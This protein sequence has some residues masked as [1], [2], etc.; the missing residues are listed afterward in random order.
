[1]VN[2]QSIDAS[3]LSV[4]YDADI[5]A[6]NAKALRRLAADHSALYT[7]PLPPNYLF[8]PQAPSSDDLTV[9]DLLLAGPTHTPFTTGVFKLHL[10][11]PSS[12]PTQPPTAFFRTPIFHP[13]VDPQTGGVCVETLK[14]D[15]DVK[16]TLRD[17]LV[18][19]G[20]LL[21][22]PNP[23]SA[24]NAEAGSLIQD[25]FQA[26]AR[27]AEMMTGIH[28]RVPARLKEAV[29]EAQ[30][31]G[32]EDD[33][34]EDTQREGI[35]KAEQTGKSRRREA[36]PSD[37]TASRARQQG[38][39]G[40]P[41]VL[42]NGSDDPFGAPQPAQR[43]RAQSM[44]DTSIADATD[45]ENDEL[46]SPQKPTVAKSAATPRR[47][48]GATARPLG[49]LEMEDEAAHPSHQNNA[50]DDSSS[51]DMEPEY[52]P[53]PAKSPRK[54]PKKQP[55]PRQL[56]GAPPALAP[57]GGEAA[58]GSSSS[59]HRNP[60]FRR[61]GPN[62][63]PPT[64]FFPN[65]LAADSP[66]SPTAGE[67]FNTP[68]PR[69]A[70][71]CRP[72][73]PS[74]PP[75]FNAPRGLGERG[76]GG[77]SLFSRAP[78]PANTSSSSSSS[79]PPAQTNKFETEEWLGRAYSEVRRSRRRRQ[80]MRK[81]PS[82]SSSSH[83]HHH[84]HNHRP[85]S[86]PPLASSTLASTAI[87]KTGK[88]SSKQTR[89]P[90]R[91]RVEGIGQATTPSDVFGVE[92]KKSE[93]KKKGKQRVG[94]SSFPPVQS[95]VSFGEEETRMGLDEGEGE[96]GEAGLEARLWASCGGHVRRWNKGD[97]DARPP[98]FRVRA[99]RW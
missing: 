66:F 18:V 70:R 65:P 83:H 43:T 12:Y 86:S 15:W 51:S 63:T 60:A 17:I 26:F 35:S 19:I 3:V 39:L 29:K 91:V 97:F 68:S 87:Q 82:S 58:E 42:Q 72:P 14:R 52:P 48:H 32:R 62:I 95:P 21:I 59:N 74:T 37:N 88:P 8:D 46:R 77:G 64:N 94:V 78:L 11:I 81:D 55:L 40:Q 84:R 30:G 10:S 28:A 24:L 53:S 2:Q 93:E 85:S 45:Q 6:Q 50:S 25:D 44:S 27:R 75:M 22:Q 20:C 31:R 7:S 54:S 69:K 47:P 9:L 36:G 41:F 16:L 23:D 34:V 89:K 5:S 71:T 56:F 13:N 4:L 96:G 61:P 1:M 92:D 79:S 98:F 67:T 99:A 33:E 57:P 73:Q 38:G 90:Q 80:Q 76:G 49:E